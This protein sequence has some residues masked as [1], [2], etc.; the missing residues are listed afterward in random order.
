M[1]EGGDESKAR[2]ICEV[3]RFSSSINGCKDR[4]TIIEVNLFFISCLKEIKSSSTFLLIDCVS[5][6]SDDV[7]G[8]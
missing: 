7:K 4:E 1:D 3:T 8:A 5:Q 2:S 6:Q